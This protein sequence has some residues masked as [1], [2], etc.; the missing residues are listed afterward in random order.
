M[1]KIEDATVFNSQPTR[2]LPIT[3]NLIFKVNLML[4]IHW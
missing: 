2:E 4:K 3:H 1:R